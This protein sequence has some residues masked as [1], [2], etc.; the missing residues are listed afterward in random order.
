MSKLENENNRAIFFKVCS[1]QINEMYF[2]FKSPFHIS[3]RNIRDNLDYTHNITMIN[4]MPYGFNYTQ[5]SI[6][7]CISDRLID[8]ANYF[9]K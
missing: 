3:G 8:F 4:A 9:A 5:V 6:N 7:S 1:Y 2:V